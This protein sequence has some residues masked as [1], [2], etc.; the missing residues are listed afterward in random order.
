M[1]TCSLVK[2]PEHPRAIVQSDGT[3]VREQRIWTAHPAFNSRSAVAFRVS[4]HA[5]DPVG[6]TVNLSIGTGDLPGHCC[7]AV[8]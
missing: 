4:P 1:T 2:A 3:A 7:W 8:S 5:P 6:S